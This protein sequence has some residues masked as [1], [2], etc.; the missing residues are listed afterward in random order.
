[1]AIYKNYLGDPTCIYNARSKHLLCAVNPTGSCS[2]CAHYTV[3]TRPTEEAKN[4][5]DPKEASRKLGCYSILSKQ[6][7]TMLLEGSTEKEILAL[8]AYSAMLWLSI[9][10]K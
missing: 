9:T 4:F 3:G 2:D 10:R 1:M 7:P 6:D 5:S 8:A